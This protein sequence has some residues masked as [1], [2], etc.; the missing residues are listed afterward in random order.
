MPAMNCPSCCPSCSRKLPL[1]D[2][3]AG[4]RVLCA[5]CGH[6]FVAPSIFIEREEQTAIEPQRTAP[7]QPANVQASG[8]ASM[9][10]AFIVGMAAATLG[11]SVIWTVLDRRPAT[12]NATAATTD[13]SN[14]TS[15]PVDS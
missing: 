11:F 13:P 3:D 2:A 7:P 6:L 14:P 10:L 12:I 5:A 8:R 9:S 4:Q 15:Q 1:R